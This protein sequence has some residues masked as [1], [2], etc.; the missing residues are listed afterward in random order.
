MPSYYCVCCNFTTLLKSNYTSHLK[1]NKHIV[2]SQ[3][4]VNKSQHRVNIKS[5]SNQQKSTFSQHLDNNESTFSQHQGNIEPTTNHHLEKP[6]LTQSQQKNNNESTKKQQ[7]VNIKSTSSQH[8][9]NIESTSLFVCKYCE[10][11]F[12]FKQSMYR[13]IKY[14]C[15]KNKTEDLTE[16]VRLLNNQLE[17]QQNQLENQNNQLQTQSKQIEKLMGKLEINSS[18]NNNTINNNNITL[19]NYNDTDVSHL[20][21]DDY[22]KCIKKVCFCVMGLIE[23]VHFNPDKPEN[24][25]VYI[26]NIK[27]KYMMIYQNNKWNLTNKNELDRLYDDKELMIDQWIEEN[28]DPEMEKF[29]NRY[30]DLKKDDKTMQM[31][32]DEIKLLMFNN[33]NLIE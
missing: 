22:K 3:P 14:S 30:L 18:F 26:S 7:K 10:R 27:N 1:T 17:N 20:T 4:K 9:V 21:D 33:K 12:K 29:F 13:H 11:N 32:T 23:K 15:I 28:K 6:H 19:L 2:K 5:T 16:L 31:I 8:L 25:N 24:M